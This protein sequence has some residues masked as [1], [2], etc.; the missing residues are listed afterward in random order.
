M[1]IGVRCTT[2]QSSKITHGT[3][4]HGAG[5]VVAVKRDMGRLCVYLRDLVE[6]VEQFRNCSCVS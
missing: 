2:P 4:D 5:F 3:L 1:F 6:G